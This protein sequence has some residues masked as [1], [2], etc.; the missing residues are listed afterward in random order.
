[1]VDIKD[2]AFAYKIKLSFLNFFTKKAA[3]SMHQHEMSRPI[4]L[5]Y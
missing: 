5:F 3:H 2:L 1:M 4:N